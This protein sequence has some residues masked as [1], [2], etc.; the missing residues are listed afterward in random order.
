MTAICRRKVK[1][2]SALRF[3]QISASMRF[4]ALLAI[5]VLCFSQSAKAFDVPDSLSKDCI[6]L[7]RGDQP[8]GSGFLIVRNESNGAVLYLVTA[9]HVMQAAIHPGE[10]TFRIRV[11]SKQGDTAQVIDYPIIPL[12]GK[13]WLEVPDPAVDLAV[14][15]LSSPDDLLSKYDVSPIVISD[16]ERGWIAD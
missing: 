13:P 2:G 1:N 16:T 12:D 5:L 14:C 4:F 11:N 7:M 9:K 6:F 10:L 8:I 3:F 15:I